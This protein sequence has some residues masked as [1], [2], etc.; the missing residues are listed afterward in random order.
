VC[1]AHIAAYDVL[2]GL[3]F[4]RVLFRSL[5]ESDER[6]AVGR[7]QG[8]EAVARAGPLPTVQRDRLLERG[9]PAVVEEMLRA[10]EVEER[11]RAEVQIGRESC[12]ARRVRHG[13][14]ECTTKHQ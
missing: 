2:P 6:R 8:L 9:R 7:W 1:F 14:R 13:V 10:A 4:R 11:L 12:R 3:E 5:K